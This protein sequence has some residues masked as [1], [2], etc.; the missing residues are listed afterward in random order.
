M[1]FSWPRRRSSHGGDRFYS[2]HH[3]RLNRHHATV[4]GFCL[5]T[6]S[7]LFIFVALSL[8]IIK[9]VYLLQLNGHPSSSLPATSIGTELRFGVWGFCV[10]RYVGTAQSV[11]T[12]FLFLFFFV[13]C[14]PFPYCFPELTLSPKLPD[15]VLIRHVHRKRQ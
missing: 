10:T 4:T 1:A 14:P 8:P 7:L 5:F 9:S 3:R 6:A 15:R 13:F 2:R 12:A 11:T